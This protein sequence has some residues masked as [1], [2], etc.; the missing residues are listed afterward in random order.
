LR[1]V[2]GALEERRGRDAE[3]QPRSRAS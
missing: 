2:A 3:V 1:V